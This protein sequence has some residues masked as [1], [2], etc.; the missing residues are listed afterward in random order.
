MEEI[1]KVRR[2][3]FI[4]TSLL[5]LSQEHEPKTLEYKNPNSFYKVSL[6]QDFSI[7]SLK[8]LGLTN[9]TK[10]FGKHKNKSSLAQEFLIESDL[11]YEKVNKAI[12]QI[13]D[14]KKSK[15]LTFNRLDQ[16]SHSSELELL[17]DLID[18][19][20]DQN[21]ISIN[22]AILNE[23]EKDLDHHNKLDQYVDFLSS[24]DNKLAKI[25]NC[26]ED[27]DVLFFLGS[28]QCKKTK[29]K[30]KMFWPFLIYQ[31]SIKIK[32]ETKKQIK[33]LNFIKEQLIKFNDQF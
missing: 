19:I 5:G 22:L 2:I 18:Y 4:S 23:F 24:F 27:S 15:N 9:L 1:I 3:F 28:Y 25:I 17:D 16:N 26:L 21:E 6:H 32:N 31:K 13:F 33:D 7:T 11:I 8:K 20:N 12:E 30:N 10:L 14:F 29:Y